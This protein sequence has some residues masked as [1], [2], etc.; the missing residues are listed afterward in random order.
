MH[1]SLKNLYLTVSESP[2][3][4]FCHFYLDLSHASFIG[5]FFLSFMF[6]VTSGDAGIPVGGTIDP[7]TVHVI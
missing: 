1:G 5:M 4:H 6:P 7:Y 2:V 3:L